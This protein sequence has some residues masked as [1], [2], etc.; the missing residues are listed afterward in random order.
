MEGEELHGNL[1]GATFCGEHRTAD[2][3]R[4]FSIDDRHPA[5][6]RTDA[7]GVSVIGEIYEMPLDIL[8]HVLDTE[9]DGLG[10]G[11][12]E[13]EGGARSLGILWTD[14]H[15]PEAALDISSYGDWRRYRKS[16][17]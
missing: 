17:A 16:A 15:L 11:V 7:G 3:Y 5:M 12:V 2:C 6:I 9:P 4:L 14:G 10:V 8:A 13:L 1:A